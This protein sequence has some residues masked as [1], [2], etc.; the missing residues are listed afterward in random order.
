MICTIS[1][2]L[3][4]LTAF[5]EE[6]KMTVQ[7]ILMNESIKNTESQ[8]I[9]NEEKKVENAHAPI[10]NSSQKPKAITLDVPLL[11]QMDDPKLFNGCEVTSLAM[12]LK[13][14]GIV[15]TKNELAEKVKKV[16]FTYENGLKGNPHDGFVGDMAKGPGLSVYHGPIV[17]LAKKYVGE[18][19]IDLTGSEPEVIYEQISKEL[20]V[21]VIT[22]TTFKPVQNFQTWYTPSGKVKVTF[23]VHSVVVTG[24]DEEYV[25]LNNPYGKKNQKVNKKLF[26]DSW[27]Q[28]GRQAVVI[29]K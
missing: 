25:Y 15:I 13:Y 9:K 10:N 19:V 6:G 12:V 14:H 20:P 24:F 18:R 5:S 21:W 17:Q 22:T 7:T 3:F 16:P 27:I 28:M 1:V 29:T 26:E 11:N 2:V 4:L 8:Q 23:N